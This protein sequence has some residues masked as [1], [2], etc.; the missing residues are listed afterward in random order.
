MKKKHSDWGVIRKIIW[1]FCIIIALVVF[2]VCIVLFLLWNNTRDPYK[3]IVDSDSI[4]KF[5]Q[6]ALDAWHKFNSESSLPM[7]WSALIDLDNDGI[8]EIFL[9][10]WAW[11]NDKIYRYWWDEFIDISSQYKFWKMLSDH[12]L[13]ASSV[14]LDGNWYTD[15]IVSRTGTVTAYYNSWAWFKKE[16]IKVDLQDNTSPLGLSFWDIDRDGDL[17]IFVSWYIRKDLMNGLTNF[18]ENYGWRSEL[19]LNNG[20]NTFSNI[21]DSA[22]LDYIHNT[23]QGVFVDLNKDTFLDLVVAYDTGEPRIY[24]NNWNLTFSLQNNP[25]TWKF[26]YPMGIGLWDYNNDGN[27]DIFFSNI[28]S[29]LPKFMVKWDLNSTDNLEL[30]WFLLQN[31]GNFNFQEVADRVRIKNFEFSWWWVFHDMN[32]D[33]KQDLI[34]AENFVDLPFYKIF[35]LPGRFLVQKDDGSF[36]ST[37]NI[38]WVMNEHFWITP[39]VTDFNKDWNQDLVWV[40]IAWKSFVYIQTN[41]VKNNYLDLE[42][43]ETAYYIWAHVELTLVDGSILYDTNIIGEWLAS[44]QSNVLHFGLWKS[45]KVERIRIRLLNEKQIVISP[46]S[47]N[48]TIRVADYE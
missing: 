19:L 1:A 29:S 48:T 37:E 27:I 45:D 34:V 31:N 21:T 10:W 3:N 13:A 28:W 38:S 2:A 30:W 47:I 14:D 33:G 11:Q 23:F 4:P 17:D 40:N 39:L 25:H 35:R 22:R 9:G 43:P 44:D 20:D 24:K 18:S 36:W 41:E 8:D 46:Q 12:T 5:N 32:N 6:I 42:F 16:K 7:R 15:L 26:S